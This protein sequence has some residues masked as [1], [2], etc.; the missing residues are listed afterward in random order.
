MIEVFPGEKEGEFF[1]RIR[2]R[3]GE[4][5][6]VSEAYTSHADAERGA[7]DLVRTILTV[8]AGL[9]YAFTWTGAPPK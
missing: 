3:N 4:I 2:G 7:N 8:V 6:A 5:Q 1:F 9:N